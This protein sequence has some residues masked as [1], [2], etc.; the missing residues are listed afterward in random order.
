MNSPKNFFFKALWATFRETFEERSSSVALSSLTHGDESLNL[1]SLP[2]KM[3]HSDLVKLVKK[4]SQQ[5]VKLR[6]L[7]NADKEEVA[8]NPLVEATIRAVVKEHLFPKVQFI[9]HDDLFYDVKNK[10]SI[11]NFVM[12]HCQIVN[13]LDARTQFWDTYKQV[14]R[15][16]IKVSRNVAHNA[17]KKKFFGEFITIQTQLTIITFFNLVSQYLYLMPYFI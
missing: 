9:R 8:Y 16:Q 6:K 11:G 12:N 10:K 7:V 4:L 5:N 15:K 17:L 3:D 1:A 2:N 13:D 14:V